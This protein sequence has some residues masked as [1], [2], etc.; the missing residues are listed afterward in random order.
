M[1]EEVHAGCVSIIDAENG[2][3]QYLAAANGHK[4]RAGRVKD[5]RVNV[6]YKDKNIHSVNQGQVTS[7]KMQGLDDPLP[8][9]PKIR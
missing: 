2:S 6:N 7:F 3:V 8:Q 1:E 9:K 5:R 4:Y